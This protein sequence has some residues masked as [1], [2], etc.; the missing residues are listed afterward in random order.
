MFENIGEKIKTLATV[1]FWAQAISFV[2][3]AFSLL[4]IGGTFSI[5]GFFLI[6]L[7]PLL[8]WCS[9]FL[10]YG[11]GEF[12]DK[13]KD[14]ESNTRV[15]VERMKNIE[16]NMCATF[17]DQKSAEHKPVAEAEKKMDVIN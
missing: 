16:K 4:N 5:A 1:I 6:V 15:L 12:V 13:T 17:V 2:L 14:I 7:G 3:L 10:L 8:A 11:F 9:A